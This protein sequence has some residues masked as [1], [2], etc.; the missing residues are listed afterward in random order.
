MNEEQRKQISFKGEKIYVGIDVHL[1]SWAVSILTES[2][3]MGKPKT[4]PPVPEKLVAYLHREFPGAEYYSVYEAGF[5]GFWIHDKLTQLGVNNIVVN[6]GDVPTTGSERLRKTDAVDSRKLA[7][8]LRAKQLNA[9]YTPSNTSLELRSL[10]RLKNSITK[11]TTRQKNRI[12]SLLRLLGIEIPDEFLIQQSNWSKRF[13]KWVKDVQTQTTF[14]RD[15]LDIEIQLFENLRKEKLEVMRAIRRISRTDEYQELIGHLLSV[16]GI[17]L[18]TAMSIL[19]EVCDP[20]RFRSAEKF[21]SYIGLIPMCHSSGEHDGTANIT[22]RSNA[23]LRSNIIEC[24]WIA[25]RNDPALNLVFV[26]NCRKMTPAKAIVK[27]ARKL[28]NRIFYV[29]KNNKD[30]VN[31]VVS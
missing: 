3:S 11:D 16:P 6:P 5:C 9:I 7:M 17:G 1:K 14:G 10:I 13:I 18:P 20:E 15:A 8:G 25:I 2:A 4:M 26:K 19:S 24:A 30:Y 27:V 29:L 23:S 22:K 31:G 21:A 28:S 12:K